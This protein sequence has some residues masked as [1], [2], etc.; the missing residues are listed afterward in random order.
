MCNM[1]T[2]KHEMAKAIAP[3]NVTQIKNAKPKTTD[4]VL[5]D[6][7]GLYLIVRPS[8]TKNFQFKYSHPVT[9][10]RLSISLGAFPDL[11]LADAREKTRGLRKQVTSGIDPSSTKREQKTAEMTR[12]ATTLRSVAESWIDIKRTRVT[13]DYAED[14]W[15]SLECH[16]FPKLGDKPI[17]EVNAPE[18]IKI[19]NPLRVKG[20][21]ETVKRICQRLNE[22]MIYATNIGLITHNPIAGIKSAFPLPQKKSQ[23]TIEPSELP[24]FL[25][26]L[27]LANLYTPTRCLIEFQLHTMAR[28]S[29]AAGALWCEIN[30]EEKTWEISA[31]RMKMRRKHVVPLSNQII[32]LLDY[33]HK[34]SGHRKYIFPN[35][36]KPLEHM[37]SQTA[38]MAIRRMGFGGQLVAHGLRSL[39][40]TIL[41]ENEFNPDWIEAALAHADENTIRGTYNRALYLEQRR[42]MMQWW[43]DHIKSAER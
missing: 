33:M 21:L 36:K 20:S 35:A 42:G 9:K 25:Q 18:T 28:P 27:R 11:G 12:L 22:I 24:S 43:S 29:E 34:Y 31:E 5:S 38:N 16:V 10:K 15:R 17:T 41:N 14:I 39:A 3:L 6:G 30:W 8:G 4:Y 19:L 32:S 40:S 2:G 37:N 23:P 13:E 26:A 1:N 7:D